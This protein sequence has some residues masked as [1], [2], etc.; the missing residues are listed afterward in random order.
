MFKNKENFIAVLILLL[1]VLMMQSMSALGIENN[2]KKDE[3]FL[4]KIGA[5]VVPPKEKGCAVVGCRRISS[6]FT[7]TLER[8]HYESFQTPSE[9]KGTC[10]YFGKTGFALY[11]RDLEEKKNRIEK[12]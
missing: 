9:M 8:H 6:E 12:K 4:I 7:D 10:W 5:Y 2:V 11:S 3:E 1:P